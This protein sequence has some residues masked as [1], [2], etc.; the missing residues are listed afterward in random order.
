[1]E[2]I[3][4]KVQQSGLIEINLEDYYDHAQRVCIDM[5]DFLIEF[6]VG[7]SSAYILKEKDFREKLSKLDTAQFNESLVAIICSV[8][9]V[10]P[11]WAYMLLSLTI[12][13]NAKKVVVG[14][15]ENLENIVFNEALNQ[16]NLNDYVGS[17]IV[18]K[19]C[20][21]FNIPLNAY[22]TLAS[23]LKPVAKSIMFGEPCSTVP[24]YKKSK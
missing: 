9:A 23:K 8:D 11:T 3:V 24:L 16:I 2:E 21:K 5:K 12:S 22:A 6:S 7:Q 19:G 4:N 13:T 15:L 18:I 14:S 20:N 1:M 17:K 10:V